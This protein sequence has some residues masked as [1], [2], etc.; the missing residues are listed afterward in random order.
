MNENCIKEGTIPVDL[1]NPPVTAP[2]AMLPNTSCFPRRAS[3]EELIP[4]Y[5]SAVGDGGVEKQ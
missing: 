4:L 5:T 1:Y 2:A 3:I